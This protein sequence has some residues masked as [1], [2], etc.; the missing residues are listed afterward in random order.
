MLLRA[1]ECKA[2]ACKTPGSRPG[3]NS[4]RLRPLTQPGNVVNIMD[5]FLCT[6]S[7]QEVE[8]LIY[9]CTTRSIFHTF[10]FSRAGSRRRGCVVVS[11][12]KRADSAS[13]PGFHSVVAVYE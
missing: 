13:P 5:A 9:E 12:R 3:M 8:D 11:Q 7:P 6:P 4:R 10:F 1:R 2:N